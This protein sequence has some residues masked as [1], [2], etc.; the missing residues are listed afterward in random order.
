[1]RDEYSCSLT[2]IGWSLFREMEDA[3]RVAFILSETLAKAV[4]KAR[5]YGL[6]DTDSWEFV[7]AEVW[8]MMNCF[9]QY[10]ASDTE[11]RSILAI[12]LSHL[13]PD[14]YPG[15]ERTKGQ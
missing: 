2:A 12:E 1:M 13:F 4:G 14:A 8:T 9:R 5:A 3:D 10:G 7:Q 15:A 11:P 6:C